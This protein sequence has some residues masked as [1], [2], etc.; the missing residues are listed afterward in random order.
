[1]FNEKKSNLKFIRISN[2]LQL[3]GLEF[4]MDLYLR[5][6][7]RTVFRNNNSTNKI[8][9]LLKSFLYI[10]DLVQKKGEFNNSISILPFGYFEIG[11]K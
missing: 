4:Y 6:P 9:R 1:M 10:S 7:G 8:V 11:Q 3:P 2:I 5:G